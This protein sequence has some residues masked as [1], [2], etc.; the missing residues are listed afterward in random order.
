MHELMH[1]S[2][3]QSFASSGSRID[4]VCELAKVSK[5][6]C[7][8]RLARKSKI[9]EDCRENLL[10]HLRTSSKHYHTPYEE[11]RELVDCDLVVV[12][13]GEV[14]CGKKCFVVL[15]LS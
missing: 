13:E 5:P 2:R 6:R 12:E 9:R 3:D 4:A 14:C 11:H 15:G 10:K 1:L 7:S 8:S